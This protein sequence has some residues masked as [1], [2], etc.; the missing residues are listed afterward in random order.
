MNQRLCKPFAWDEDR[1]YDRGKV[2]TAEEPSELSGH[3]SLVTAVT[4]IVSI[5]T[6]ARCERSAL[7]RLTAGSACGEMTT[8]DA[9]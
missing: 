9:G 5:P 1:A 3:V 4:V 8:L 7:A 2:M 6:L